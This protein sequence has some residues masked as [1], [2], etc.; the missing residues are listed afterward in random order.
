METADTKVEAVYTEAGYIVETG[1]E[2]GLKTAYQEQITEVFDLE[3]AVMYPGF[4]D[5]HL[6]IMGHGEKLLHL[7]LSQ[8]LS[9]EAVLEAIKQKITTLDPGEWLIA[10]GWNENQWEESRIIDKNELDAISAEHPMMLTRVCRHAI[11]VNSKAL[12]LAGITKRTPDPQGGKIVCDKQGDPT[13]YL[14]DQAQELVKETVPEES[15]KRLK[16]TIQ[17]AIED[18]LRLGLVGGHSEDLFYYGGFK[19]T[20]EAYQAILPTKYK[21]RAHLLVHHQVFDEMVQKGYRYGDGGEFT[22]LGAMKFFSDGALGGRTAWLKEPYADDPDNVGIPIHTS[23]DLEQLFQKARSYQ[24]PVAVHAI[25]D[26]AVEEIVKLIAKYPLANGLRDRIIH[27]QVV[28]NQL[29][30]RL[31]ET[32]VVLDIQPSFVVS[33]FPW[34]IKR[35]GTERAMNSYPWQT[36]TTQGIACAGGSDAPIEEVNPLLGIQ[37]AVTRRSRIDQQIYGKDQQLSV[38]D[39]ISLY[40]KGSAF[41]ISHE[42]NRGMIKSGYTADFTVLEHDL[43]SHEPDRFHEIAVKATI[44]DGEVMYQK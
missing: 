18:L 29:I 33:D 38:F 36:Y 32:A 11:I 44:V 4:V 30:E 9:A 15:E 39:A 14:L 10:E 40:T 42:E 20:L 6:H 41:V 8:M 28:D 24:H 23:A 27:A 17:V 37:A 22:T 13:G 1:T 19:R 35:L 26:Q 43:F 3:G 25:G 12:E 31:K 5:S 7:D 34:V 2:A 16:Q 21:F